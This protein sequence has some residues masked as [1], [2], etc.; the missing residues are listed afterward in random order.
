MTWHRLHVSFRWASDS[1]R[2]GLDFK[3]SNLGHIARISQYPALDTS[4][5]TLLS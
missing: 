1:T 2:W 4:R 5:R 3:Q